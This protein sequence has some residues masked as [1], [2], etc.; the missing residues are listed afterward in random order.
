MGT[1]DSYFG[2]RYLKDN[3]NLYRISYEYDDFPESPREWDNLGKMICHHRNY[4]LGDAQIEDWESYFIS[5]TNMNEDWYYSHSKYTL[6]D[7]V[8]RWK[9][10][11]FLV[12]ELSICDHSG[13]SMSCGFGSGWDVSNIGFIYVDK[14]NKDVQ[15]YLK[16][17][18]LKET[19]EWV[20]GV[21]ESE[22]KIYSK[23]LEG[24]VYC[25]IQ[26]LYDEET[27]TW[28]IMENC[29]SYYFTDFKDQEISARDFLSK[30]AVQLKEKDVMDAI[31]TRSLDVL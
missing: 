27:D 4:N 23:Y 7:L 31:K 25:L 29:G 20:L 12:L 6:K 14:D 17:H 9:K 16:T 1:K 2:S 26:E 8:G 19:K 3:G 18:T 22:V 28:E 24:Q 15:D 21:L 11:K 10:T 5:E 13:I 30:D